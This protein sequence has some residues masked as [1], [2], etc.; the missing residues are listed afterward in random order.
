MSGKSKNPRLDTVS[1]LATVLGCPIGYL[2]GEMQTPEYAP[3]DMRL[4]EGLIA[5]I[6]DV[7]K[8]Y[9]PEQIARW[10]AHKYSL[11]INSRQSAISEEETIDNEIKTLDCQSG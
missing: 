9:S 2:T 10:V 3:V 7:K 4:L 5:K 8:G 1:R 6:V 11:E